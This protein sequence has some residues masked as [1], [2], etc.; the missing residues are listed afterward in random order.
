MQDSNTPRLAKWPFFLGNALLLALAWFIVHQ[1]RR[2]MGSWEVLACVACVALGAF[3]SIWA[4][5]LEYRSAE[6]LVETGALTSVVAQMQNIEQLAAQITGA[7]ARWQTVQESAD[8]TARQATEISDKIADEA[9]AFSEFLQQANDSEKATL[10][11]EVDKLRRVETDWLQVV[12][13]ILDHVFA[14]NRAAAHSRQPNVVEQLGRFQAACH[15]TVRRVGLNPFIAAADEPF[16]PQRHQL[17][18]GQ[19]NPAD[20]ARVGETL[21]AGYTF[22]G[23]LIRPAGVRLRVEPIEE[24]AAPPAELETQA[25]AQ[26][27]TEPKT[28]TVTEPAEGEL[29]LA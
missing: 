14:L 15:D 4:F 12:V 9:K 24:P 27:N 18:E 11:L 25:E 23:R 6:K 10:R 16:D 22:Q 2:P 1:S 20:G 7:T 19:A 5:V 28:E 13:R 17:I 8:K 26:T 3:F 21:A 29:P